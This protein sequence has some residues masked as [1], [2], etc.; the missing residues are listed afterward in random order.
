MARDSTGLPATCITL[1]TEM[2][3]EASITSEARPPDTLFGS[4]RPS[5]AL[6]TNPTNG[7]SGIS[8]STCKSSPFEGRKSVGV[9]RLAVAEQRDDQREAHGRFSRGHRHDEE[10][11]DLTV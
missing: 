4:R 3:N 6:T 5:V 1:I 7:R 9:Q 10:R 2:T 11:D 8:A